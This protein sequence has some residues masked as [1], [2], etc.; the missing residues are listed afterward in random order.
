MTEFP[1]PE[2]L[3]SVLNFDPKSG[4]L[5]WKARSDVSRTWNTRYAGKPA[6]ACDRGDGYLTGTV[7]GK[8]LSA[9]RVMWALVYGAWPISEIDHINGNPSDNRILNLRLASRSENCINIAGRRHGVRCFKGVY[10]YEKLGRWV[11]K[12][13]PKGKTKHLGYFAS[14]VEAAEAYDRAAIQV[15]GEYAKTNKIMGLYEDKNRVSVRDSVRSKSHKQ[16]FA[17]HVIDDAEAGRALLRSYDLDPL[18]GL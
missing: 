5:Y 15:F 16:G 7:N 6:L 12:V 4:I 10:W 13:T 17:V 9:H 2:F 11:A 14:E 8:R 3:R 1:T 18:A